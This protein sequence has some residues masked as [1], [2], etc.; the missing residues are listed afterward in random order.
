MPVISVDSLDDPRL[1]PYRELK[2]SNLTRWSGLFV[3]EG[4]KVVERL[5][6][7]RCHAESVLVSQRQANF[8]DEARRLRADVDVLL[9][10]QELGEQL[11]GYNFHAGILGCG[12]RPE[13]AD[14]LTVGQTSESRLIVACE[15][16]NDP[17]NLGTIARLAR[18]FGASGLLLSPGCCD[19]YSRRVLRVSM[20]NLLDV[21]VCEATDF[22][23]ELRRLQAAGYRLL[24]T[25]LDDSAVPLIEVDRCA[26]TVLLVGNEAYGLS[27]EVQALCDVKVTIPMASGTDSLN[28]ALATGICLYELTLRT[29]RC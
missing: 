2:R 21:P 1:A 9:V 8:L 18:G 10:P 28:V 6:T 16:V 5:L 14:L 15:Q 23:A 11:V 20:G 24:A 7:S 12:V 27:E 26:K 29:A 3:A 17:D 13:N 19:P 4:R 22:V 25:V